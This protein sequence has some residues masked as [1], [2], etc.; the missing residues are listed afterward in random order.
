M[1]V[2]NLDDAP[3]DGQL[4]QPQRLRGAERA[5]ARIQHH[6]LPDDGVLLDRQLPVPGAPILRR[7]VR[8]SP[9][10]AQRR[11]Q[12]AVSRQ[13]TALGLISGFKDRIRIGR[14][15]QTPIVNQWVF[16][17]L[18]TSHPA[19][20]K[21]EAAEVLLL[22]RLRSQGTAMAAPERLT[23]CAAGSRSCGWRP[24]PS[25]RAPLPLSRRLSSPQG[26]SAQAQHPRH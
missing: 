24:R 4:L 7:R 17:L 15:P 13:I 2:A 11:L 21:V 10:L 26:D 3:A 12:H 6:V 20:H 14:V 25:R 22:R 16:V 9:Q 18:I 8:L 19:D 23:G 5:K 1:Y